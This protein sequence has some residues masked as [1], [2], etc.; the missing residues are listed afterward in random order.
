MKVVTGRK[1]DW[2]NKYG[3]EMDK[4]AAEVAPLFTAA[5]SLENKEIVELDW[6]IGSMIPANTVTLLSGDGGTGKS[7]LALNLAISVA[8]GG[9]L[10]WLGYKPE[11]GKALYIGAEDDMNEMHRRLNR[12]CML[13]NGVEYSDLNDLHLASLSNRDALL[14]T[15]DPKT[16][17]LY[18]TELFNDIVTKIDAERPRVVILDT[19]ADLY[20][21]NENDRAQSRMFIGQL[22]KV[23]VDYQTTIVLLSHPS[24]T[25]MASGTG[26]SGNTAWSNSVRSRL[27]MQRVKEDGYEADKTARKL[28]VMKSNYGESGTEILMHYVDGY[29]E[30]EA[31]SDALDR[32]SIDSKADRVYL[33]LLELHTQKSMRVSPNPSA[34][35]SACTV[36][37]RSDERESITKKQFA[38]AQDRLQLRDEIH[39]QEEGPPSRRIK[40]IVQGPNI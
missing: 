26:T 21:G 35:N 5:S 14:S 33:K 30:A 25:G 31:T 29:F 28:T 12:M 7:L 39:V 4:P 13:R 3:A 10:S 38:A 18:P 1:D 8:C 20:A 34:N 6:L 27:Y 15:V 16:N 22:R 9:K 23:S 24:L 32:K 19:L 37:G 17:L 2:W 11:Q 40:F 36:F